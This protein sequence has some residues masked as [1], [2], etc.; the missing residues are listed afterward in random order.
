MEHMQHL[1]EPN[2]QSGPRGTS[3]SSVLIKPVSATC[4]LACRYCF[5]HERPTDPYKA[6]GRRAMSLEVL[7]SVVA[8][9]MRL[10][11]PVATFGWQGGEPTLAGLDFFKQ[12]V[13]L[14]QRFGHGGQIVANALQTNGL[15]LDADWARFLA[16]YRFLVGIS[17]DGPREVHDAWRVDP[18]GRGS[19]DR[20]MTAMRLLRRYHVET[21]V[22]AVVHRHNADRVETIM[23]FFHDQ[24]VNFL[25]FVP[26]LDRYPEQGITEY[27][28]TS[29]Q[30]GEFLCRLFDLWY[31]NGKPEVSIRLFDN[32]LAVASG[33][34]A[35]MCELAPRCDS[36]YVVEYN[37][38]VYPCDF[39][40]TTDNRLGNLMETPTEQI[41][42]SPRRTAF[43]TGKEH[44][45]EQ[46]QE[47][48]WVGICHGG[49]LRFRYA[50]SGNLKGSN[51]LCQAMR[52]F[53]E[54]SWDRLTTLASQV[55]PPNSATL[56]GPTRQA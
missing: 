19:F 30:Y 46:C 35:E 14:Q 6:A 33:R 42:Q 40:V 49:C 31:N 47:C 9:H 43:A 51:Y 4:N 11:G 20:V 41:L 17:L 48:T 8:Q 24:N 25:Q 32:L 39:F 22:L 18:V 44:L 56:P 10:A 26:A 29:T 54:H 45:P 38:D 7:A 21:N 23:A 1:N 36:Y 13:G 50:T 2:N 16:Q 3:A 37:G 5:Y 27:S 52:T 12:V 34:P 53:L 28:I 55:Q 15:A